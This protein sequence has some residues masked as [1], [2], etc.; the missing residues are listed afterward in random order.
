V[1]ITRAS[2]ETILIQ[3]AGA[4]LTAAS[5]DGTSHAGTN[6][7][8]NDSIGYA[9]RKIGYSVADITL[10]TDADLAGVSEVDQLLDLAELRTLDNILGNLA[11][12]DITLG[13]RKESL[14]QLA[15]ALEKRIA[16]LHSY[17][18]L[19]YGIGMAELTGGVIELGFAEHSDEYDESLE[20]L[21]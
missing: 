21:S 1:T 9:L 16:R 13:P 3:R 20:S 7:S 11:L 15:S 2:V 5:M 18:E 19:E 6:E 10:I 12:V 17:I 14:S 8:L 4:Y